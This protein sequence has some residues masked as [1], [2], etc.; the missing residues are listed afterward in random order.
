[1]VGSGQRKPVP[2]ITVPSASGRPHSFVVRACRSDSPVRRESV[3]WLLP[4]AGI[5]PAAA[6][7]LSAVDQAVTFA[8]KPSGLEVRWREKSE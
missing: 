4:G 6:A 8:V 5:R 7:R 2:T 3:S 1:M